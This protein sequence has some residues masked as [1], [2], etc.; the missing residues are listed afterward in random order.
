V[1]SINDYLDRLKINGRLIVVTHH[2]IE[3]FR[4]IFTSISAL[5]KRGIS[6]TSA[7]EHLYAVGPE[8]FPL[9]VLKKSPLTLQEAK[10]VHQ[11]MHEQDLSTF[12]SFIPFVEQIEFKMSLGEGIYYEHFMLNQ[13]LSL[14][15]RGEVSPDELIKIADFDLRA[16]TDDSPFFYKFD[17]GIPS[18]LTFLLVFSSIAMIWVW[19][20]RLGKTKEGGTLRNHI[21]F[22]FLF[23]SLG[24]GFMLIEIP[25]FQKF[26]LFLGQ[27]VYSVATL[28]FSILIGAGIG[29]WI[30]GIFWRQRTFFKLRLAAII[31]SVI[32]LTYSLFLKQIFDFYL[33][34]PFLTRI[35]ISFFLLMPLG[36]FLGMP[37]PLGM[38]LLDEFGLEQYVPKMWGV[39]GIGSVL[40]SA[41]AITL[42]IRF[43]FSYSMIIG[44]LL[45]FFI[46]IIL[47]PIEWQSV[48]S[49]L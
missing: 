14:M 6:L 32:V 41:I 37:F 4:L 40:G 2:D 44:A 17:I 43:G 20:I 12:S 49:E 31:V 33:G 39:N 30:S 3:I 21:L 28:L 25:L 27:P 38:K 18:M 15:F 11:Y 36:F 1:E 13:S 23:S 35:L 7:M 42:A 5:K 10:R 9:F 8:I 48:K 29:S 47:F 46:F 45:Y 16:V 26:I 19:L 22:L 24:V 34:T